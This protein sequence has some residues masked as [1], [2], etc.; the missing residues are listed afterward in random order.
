MFVTDGI[1]RALE[2]ARTVAGDRTIAVASPSL[3]QQYLNA[4]LLDE[5]HVSVIPVLLGEGV[6][7]FDGLTGAP[8]ELESAQVVKDRL[9]THLSYRVRRSRR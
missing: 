1:E 5:I 3:A 2:R 8:I 4:D 9:A 7:F 6:R